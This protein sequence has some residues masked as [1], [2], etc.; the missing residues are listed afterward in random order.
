MECVHGPHQDI[1]D[2]VLESDLYRAIL[3]QFR[4][5]FHFVYKDMNDSTKAS[6]ILVLALYC[7]IDYG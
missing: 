6:L 3:D 7:G 5:I 2:N 1:I 4:F